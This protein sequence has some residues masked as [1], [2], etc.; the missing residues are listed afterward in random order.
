MTRYISE[1]RTRI[2]GFWIILDM[3]NYFILY[4]LTVNWNWWWSEHVLECTIELLL[5][6]SRP[7]NPRRFF[8]H[9][10]HG[11]GSEKS[12]LISFC[13]DANPVLSEKETVTSAPGIYPLNDSLIVFLGASCERPQF[14]IYR[15]GRLV[16]RGL[17][18][19]FIV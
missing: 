19:P 17:D 12:R 11:C 18:V 10:K 8:A 14:L 7:I 16:Y 1:K 2:S 9:P 13:T 6:R 15:L 5:K 4:P 3:Q